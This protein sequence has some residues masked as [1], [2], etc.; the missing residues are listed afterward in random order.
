MSLFFTIIFQSL[1]F[2]IQ[3]LS[4]SCLVNQ[5]IVSHQFI[6]IEKLFSLS[7]YTEVASIGLFSMFVGD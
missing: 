4:I 2:S 3:I 5:L 7:W 1:S 6:F